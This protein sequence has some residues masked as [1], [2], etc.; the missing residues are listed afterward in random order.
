MPL[1]AVCDKIWRWISHIVFYTE[2][3]SR[4]WAVQWAWAEDYK[5]LRQFQTCGINRGLVFCFLFV[6]RQTAII[7]HLKDRIIQRSLSWDKQRWIKTTEISF[8][9]WISKSSIICFLTACK[10]RFACG[11]FYLL[12]WIDV[13]WSVCNRSGKTIDIHRKYIP[14]FLTL[15]TFLFRG[16]S[17]LSSTMKSDKVQ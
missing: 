5:P 2:A 9:T 8:Q 7:S 14:G 4:M 17:L 16:D 15:K 13:I 12:R 11:I 3:V 6:S 10:N 1:L